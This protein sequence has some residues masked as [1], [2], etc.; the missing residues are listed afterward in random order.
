MR[1]IAHR[2]PIQTSR[3]PIASALRMMRSVP[4]ADCNAARITS[5]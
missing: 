1:T 4:R 3:A 5:A 2:K